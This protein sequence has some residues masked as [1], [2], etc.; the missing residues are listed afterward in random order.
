M[1]ATCGAELFAPRCQGNGELVVMEAAM[2]GRMRLGEC[3]KD[4]LGY[5]G[6]GADVLREM[7]RRCSGR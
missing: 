6:C 4:D 3:A 2:Y 7:D 5:I 1:V